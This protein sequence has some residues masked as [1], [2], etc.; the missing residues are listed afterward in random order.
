MAK[1]VAKRR[2]EAVHQSGINRRWGDKK[3]SVEITDKTGILLSNAIDKIYPGIVESIE[4]ASKEIYDFAF[5]NWPVRSGLSKK[6]LEWGTLI[7]D[8]EVRSFVLSKA[9]YTKY[10][11]KPT[12]MDSVWIWQEL[13]IKPQKVKAKDLI[14]ELANNIP[15]DLVRVA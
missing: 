15:K 6:L 7:N 13:L 2:F 14:K 11:H 8:K 1:R 9:N 12:P 5:E 4:T 3:T 10:I